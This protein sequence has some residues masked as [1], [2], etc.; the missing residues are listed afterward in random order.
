MRIPGLSKQQGELIK[1]A[2]HGVQLTTEQG[3]MQLS[4]RQQSAASGLILHARRDDQP[5]TLWLDEQQWCQWVEPMLAIPSLALAPAELHDLLAHWTLADVSECFDGND[6]PWPEAH[7]LQTGDAPSGLGWQLNIRREDRCLALRLLSGAESWIDKLSDN[8][9]PENTWDSAAELPLTASLLAGWSKIDAA[10]LKALKP[11]DALM[12]QKSLQV[13]HGQVALFL[14]RPLAVIEQG[15][16]SNTFYIEEMMSD[17]EDWMDITPSS[18]VNT[19]VEQALNE[20][21]VSVTVEVAQLTVSLQELSRME[22]GGMLSGV[23]SQDSLVTLKVG[24]RAIARGTLLEFD[25]QLAV[26]I[27]HLC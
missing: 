15:S 12:L 6:L 13:N 5:I 8:M 2:G 18:E 20:A 1:K 4:F 10:Q 14:E 25:S 21:M 19:S 23:V 16:E 11:G 22:A 17:F 26:K 24:N 3:S 9:F 27:D 7:S